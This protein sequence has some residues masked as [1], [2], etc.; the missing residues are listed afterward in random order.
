MTTSNESKIE[1]LDGLKRQIELRV[2]QKAVDDAAQSELKR[3]AKTAKVQGFRPGKAPLKMIEQSHGPSVRY[4]A[5]N[6]QVVDELDRIVR[7][8]DLRIA[9]RPD[10]KPK[11]GETSTEDFVFLADFEVYPEVDLG[12]VGSM[13]FTKFKSELGDSEINET[14]EILRKQRTKFNKVDRASQDQDRVTVDFTGKIDGVEFEGG[15]AESFPFV[16]GVGAMLPEFE[17]AAKGLKAGEEKTFSLAFPEDYHGKE[18]AGK[19]AE[20]TLNMKEVAEPVLPEVNEEFAKSLGQK[21]GDVEKLKEEIK[22]NLERETNARLLSRTKKSVWDELA[23]KVEMEVPKALVD[24]EIEDHIATIRKQ[25]AQT[26]TPNADT[27]PIEGET[28]RDESSRR[29]KLGLIVAHIVDT[30][31][32]KPTMEQVRARIEEISKNYEKPQEFVAYCLSNREARSNIEN[33]VLEDNVVEYF[34]SKGKVTEESIPF[35][36]LMGQQ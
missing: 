7:E 2:S 21:D 26:K 36:E 30:E 16:L 9:G 15:K 23:S 13:N 24:R 8:Q 14:I 18:V 19:T 33:S 25:L 32:V 28:F 31:D 20:F 27:L 35:K 22:A 5:L 6:K 11:E 34:L 3:I 10:I 29:V 1:K 12:D 4:E 17:E